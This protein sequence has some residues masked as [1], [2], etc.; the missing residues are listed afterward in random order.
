ML[1][2]GPFHSSWRAFEF[3]FILTDGHNVA[4]NVDSIGREPTNAAAI[5]RQLCPR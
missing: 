5:A 2:D 3:G 1:L 4:V